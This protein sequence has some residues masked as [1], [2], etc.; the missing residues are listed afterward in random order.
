M[1]DFLAGAERWQLYRVAIFI[2]VF[3]AHCCGSAKQMT[4]FC[5]HVRTAQFPQTWKATQTG[6]PG[7]KNHSTQDS[8]LVPHGGT[9]WAIHDLA[10]Q[11]GRDGAF[12]A[13]YGRG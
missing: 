6:P 2:I 9:D 3:S 11:S 10:S 5:M 1:P 7:H 13:F 4:V 8:H 12:F